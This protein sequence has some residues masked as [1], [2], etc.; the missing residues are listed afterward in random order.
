MQKVIDLKRFRR[1]LVFSTYKK[2][3]FGFRFRVFNYRNVVGVSSQVEGEFH[4]LFGDWDEGKPEREIVFDVMVRR[5]IGM[6]F[7]FESSPGKYQ[8]ISPQVGIFLDHLHT[9]REMGAEKNFLN[10]S[11]IRGMFILRCSR[12]GGKDAPKC[13][14][15]LVNPFAENVVLSRQ[16]VLFLENYYGLKGVIPKDMNMIDG[17]ELDVERYRTTNV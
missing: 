4:V 3:G 8:F 16:H 7:V 13:V 10:L 14:A 1:L 2:Y 12:K 9:A 11:A 6:L 17:G 5:N 15:A